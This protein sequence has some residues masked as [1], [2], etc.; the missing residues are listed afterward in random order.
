MKC[1]LS[2]KSQYLRY[3]LQYFVV[4]RIL[5]SLGEFSKIF[6][7]ILYSQKHS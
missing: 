6:D 3:K 7:R 5:E 2:L 4:A 1:V